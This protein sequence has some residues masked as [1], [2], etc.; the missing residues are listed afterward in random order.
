MHFRHFFFTLCISLILLVE[1]SAQKPS[2][3]F[4]HLKLASGY[5]ESTTRFIK[6]DSWGYLWIGT[7]NGL[8]KFDGYNF[9]TYKNDYTNKYSISNND[10]KEAFL[11]SKG[12]FWIATRGGINL[13]DPIHDRFYNFL[14]NRYQC[15]KE[16]DGDIEDV[17]EDENG[18]IWVV[19]GSDGLFKITSLDKKAEN[20]IFNSNDNSQ[21][22]YTLT[23]DGNG[24]L[25][26]GTRDGLL[27]FDTRTNKYTD[28][29]ALFG[30]GF[31][32][33]KILFEEE[34]NRL[35]LCTTDG[36]KII[37]LTTNK[38]KEYRHNR[39]DPFSIS[40]DNILKVV[41]YDNDNYLI[42]VD[43]GGVDYFNQKTEKFYHYTNDNEGQISANN[44]TYVY[45]DSKNNIWIGTFMN[46]VDYSSSHTNMFS[47]V[48]NNPLSENSL[49]KGIVTSFL[50]DK[51]GNLW[52][53]TDGGGLYIRKKDSEEFKVV[54]PNPEKYDFNKFPILSMVEDK[55]GEIWFATYGG[56]LVVL[57]PVNNRIETFLSDQKNSNTVNANN[58]V[59][60]VTVDSVGN[61]WHMGFYSGVSVYN[62]KTKNIKHYHHDNNDSTSILSDWT[63]KVFC[64]SKG[65]IW[66]TSFKGLNRYNSESGNFTPYQFSLPNHYFKDCNYVVDITEA[67]D[68]N[69]WIGTMEVGIICFNRKNGTYKIYTIEDG[70]SNNSIKGIIE[71]DN[72]NLWISTYNGITKFNITT[73]KAIPYTV[74]DGIPPY[75]YYSSSKYKDEKGRIYFGN[76]KGFLIINP[77]LNSKNSF[78]PPIV[79]TG[80][81]IFGKDLDEYFANRDSSI[82]VSF[83]KEIRLN[84][85]QNEI[86]IDYAA[87][88]FIN[89][90]R[91][92]YMYILEGFDED[93]KSVGNQ[94]Y[95]KYTNL[96]PGD[97]IFKVKGS[98]NDGVWNDTG[99]MLKIHISPP[100]WKTWWFIVTEIIV[101][102]AILYLAYRLRV[103]SIRHKNEELEKVVQKRTEEL[104][105]SN[106][107]LETFIY[108]AS[109]DIKGPLR[110]IIGLTTIG[111]KDVTDETSLVYFDHILR[112]TRKLDNLLADLIELTKVKES[113]IVYEKINFRELINE[114][115]A[116]FD[117]MEGFDK[118]HITVL[119]KESRDYYSDKKLLY[120]IIQ[121]LVENPIKYRDIEKDNSYLD[122]TVTVTEQSTELKFSD[123]GIGIPQEIQ[124]RVFEMFFKA[125]ERSKDTGLGLHIVKT[126]VEKLNGIITLESSPGAGSTFV[127]TFPPSV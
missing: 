38:L 91:N 31:Q 48:R 86:E 46:G 116:K 111:Q 35:W 115:L 26:I 60:S 39:K 68:S 1:L 58:N 125:R 13:Y 88:N 104:R 87:L 27:K 122:I 93:W 109:H 45:K 37:D 40:G 22:L 65:T 123:N 82:H 32:I 33:K 42:A 7:E 78:V 57:N 70:L 47:M 114:A 12:N 126:T 9:T 112:S 15:F 4:Q 3:S 14:S 85:S 18:N 127:V 117:H 119:V 103:R 43:G 94:R 66:I 113:R 41:R 17:T 61:I 98:N 50:K 92:Q 79:I 90:Q 108:K 77:S 5:S 67:S 52:V 72:K 75:P 25:W 107:Q 89:A 34:Y 28:M 11:D 24:N 53:S 55:D 106:E 71:D 97:Y 10:N 16:L 99:T 95:A 56:G 23:P 62:K 19:A 51:K 44:V 84:Y 73:K 49:N 96:D 69:L 54:N 6:E 124:D 80:F 74:Q 83:L 30:V 105:L 76:S 64:D 110:S 20:F 81:K 29:R 2:I 118:V 101:L 21:K 59:R 100:W 63:H 102:L 120:S 36:I 8:N 121:N